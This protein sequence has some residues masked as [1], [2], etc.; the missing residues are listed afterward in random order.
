MRVKDVK[1]AGLPEDSLDQED[2][3]GD[4]VIARA[5]EPQRARA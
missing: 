5:V 2:M 1:P 3:L 4:V